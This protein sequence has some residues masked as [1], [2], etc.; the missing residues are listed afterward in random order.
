[1][2]LLSADE[3]GSYFPDFFDPYGEN[4]I[5]RDT[6]WLTTGRS[7]GVFLFCHICT[8]VRN[9]KENYSGPHAILFTEEIHENEKVS[10]VTA[11]NRQEEDE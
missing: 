6:I 2:Q 10:E 3:E 8:S 11:P 7:D 4:D 9:L 1:M 5:C